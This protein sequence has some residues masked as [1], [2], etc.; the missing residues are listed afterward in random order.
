MTQGAITK[1]FRE[2]HIPRSTHENAKLETL[3][4]C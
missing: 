3:V 1:V 2:A 4:F